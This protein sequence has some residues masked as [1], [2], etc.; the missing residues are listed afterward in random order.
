MIFWLGTNVV[1]LQ[2][3]VS[4]TV[5]TFASLIVNEPETGVSWSVTKALMA[6]TL[7]GLP[8]GVPLTV[9]V[10]VAVALRAL[11]LLAMKVIVAAPVCP[12]TGVSVTLREDPVPVIEILD[13]G[14]SAAFDDKAKM[15]TLDG[16]ASLIGNCTVT[17]VLV[18]VEMSDTGPMV[19][20]WA[21]SAALAAKQ[22]I[23]NNRAANLCV[24]A[25]KIVVV[26]GRGCITKLLLSKN[27]NIVCL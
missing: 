21:C 20:D 27:M 22:K 24:C 16:F 10:K 3:P 13:V 12:A 23:A 14:I 2:Y 19:N 18:G 8:I 11:L 5:P 15:F 26:V 9:T 6:P 1:S 4:V 17:G 7:G 25:P